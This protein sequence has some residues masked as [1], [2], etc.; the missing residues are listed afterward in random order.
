LCAC[1]ALDFH[2]PLT[3]SPPLARTSAWT[4]ALVP[5]LVDDRSPSPDLARIVELIASGRFEYAVGAVVN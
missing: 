2:A 4:R 1:Q 5:T 3:T